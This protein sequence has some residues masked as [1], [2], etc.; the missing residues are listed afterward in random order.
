MNAAFIRNLNERC[1][2]RTVSSYSELI[3]DN[4]TPD[5]VNHLFGHYGHRYYKNGCIFEVQPA[6]HTFL[7]QPIKPKP[8][9]V[10]RY[11][12]MQKDNR[13][14]QLVNNERKTLIA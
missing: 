7:L 2:I 13:L 6:R 4:V 10:K 9:T 8:M 5:V 1:V 3:M 12:A 14:R 11:F